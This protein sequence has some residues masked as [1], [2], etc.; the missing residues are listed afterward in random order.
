MGRKAGC[1]RLSVARVLVNPPWRG[2]EAP[3]SNPGLG[4]AGA[5]RHHRTKE[6]FL[7]NLLHNNNN[8]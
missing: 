8:N 1:P 7:I 5:E 6:S 3:D 4:G 2:R